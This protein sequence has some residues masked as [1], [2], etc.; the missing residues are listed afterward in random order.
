MTAPFDTLGTLGVE[1]EFYA[2]DSETLMPVSASNDL[3]AD[4]PAELDG[5]LGTELFKFVIETRTEKTWSLAE[6]RDEILAKRKALKSHAQSYGYEIL[7][8]GLHPAARWNEHEHIDKPRYTKQ[9]DRIRYPQYRNITA[10]LHVHVG[11]DDPD[12]A[13]WVANEIR[14]FLP[15]ML[16]LSANSPF[17]YGTDTGLRSARALVFENLPNT[18][19]PTAFDSWNEFE[20][21]ESPMVEQGSIVDRGEIWWDVR[22]NSEYGTVEVR[23]PDSQVDAERT[24]AFVSLIYTLVMELSR[25]YAAGE[26]NTRARRELLD[27]NKWRAI[28]HGHDASFLRL[29]ALDE[30]DGVVE[31][32]EMLHETLDKIEVKDRRAVENLLDYSGAQRQ[33]D[34]YSSDKNDSFHDVLE[35]LRI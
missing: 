27:Q 6:A 2:V 29:G 14:I 11:V 16:A 28:R 33:L 18:G 26:E 23:S 10:G 25:R 17:W 32:D 7:A 8:A 22:P 35:I 12:K 20:T 3:L 9:L 4:P 13:V 19:M 30:A 5:K 1:E 24:Y 21:F 31:L 34:V 15:M